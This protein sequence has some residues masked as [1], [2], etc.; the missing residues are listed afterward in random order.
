MSTSNWSNDY[1]D[2]ENIEKGDAENEI[3]K[4]NQPNE[5]N[6]DIVK[7]NV[8]ENKIEEKSNGLNH[9]QYLSY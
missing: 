3:A 5:S 8:N 9:H 6:D 7:D 4:P 2:W 1:S